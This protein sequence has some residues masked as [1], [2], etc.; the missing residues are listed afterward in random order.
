MGEFIAHIEKS[1][2]INDNQDK[3]HVEFCEHFRKNWGLPRQKILLINYEEKWFFGWV[4]RVNAKKCELLGLDKTHTYLYQQG[5][6]N[7]VMAVVLASFAFDGSME[8]G[9]VDVKLGE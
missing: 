1:L 9:G 8:N 7:K 5:H 2:L 3:K 4:C 6:I